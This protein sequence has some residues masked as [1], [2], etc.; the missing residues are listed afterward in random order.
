MSCSGSCLY[1]GNVASVAGIYGLCPPL[2]APAEIK[3]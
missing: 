2:A 3:G 1:I